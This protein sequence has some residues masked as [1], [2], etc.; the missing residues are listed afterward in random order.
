M[1]GKHGNLNVSFELLKGLMIALI[2]ASTK[3]IVA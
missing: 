2:K 3:L 1:A